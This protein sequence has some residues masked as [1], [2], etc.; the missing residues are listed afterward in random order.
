MK[1]FVIYDSFASIRQPQ[2]VSPDG[3]CR[4][5]VEEFHPIRPWEGRFS[6]RPFNR[7]HR[8]LLVVDDTI[9][10][11]G[12][13]NVGPNTP[14]PG[15]LRA[16]SRAAMR[17]AIRRS[18][19]SAPAH[20]ISFAN[21][22]TPGITSSTAGAFAR[23]SSCTASTIRAHWRSKQARLAGE[24]RRQPVPERHVR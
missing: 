7:D 24:S 1:V 10:G 9:A 23:P 3:S 5:A 17:R 18:E 20:G 13:L 14:A 19:S 11:M 6:W 8:K 2:D 12:G 21:S 22:P 4:R 15:S 16:T